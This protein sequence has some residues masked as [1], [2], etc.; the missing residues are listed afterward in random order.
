MDY[1]DVLRKLKGAPGRKFA[2]AGWNGKNMFIYLV[3]GS[4]FE[5]NRAPLNVIYPEG[6][7]IEYR[8]HIDLK[9]VQGRCGPWLASQTDTLADDWFEVDAGS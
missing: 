1:G 5:V 7:S 8:P 9:D 2:R 4:T 6:T 3:P